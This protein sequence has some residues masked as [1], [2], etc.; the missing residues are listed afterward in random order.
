MR[1]LP[2]VVLAGGALLGAAVAAGALGVRVNTTPSVPVGFYMVVDRAPRI[3]DYVFVCPPDIE[4]FRMARSRGYLADGIGCPGGYGYL[5][6]ILLAAKND[7]VAVDARGVTVNGALLPSSAPLSQDQG[8]R[9][10][11]AFRLAPTTLGPDD[12]LL[13]TATNPRSFDARYFGP[14]PATQIKATLKP[15]LTW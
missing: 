10:L 7:R 9:P 8:G 15:L 2:T 12:V 1:L 6:K 11:P 4:P 5:V 14:L 13:M 3:G